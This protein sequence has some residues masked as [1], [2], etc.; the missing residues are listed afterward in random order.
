MIKVDSISNNKVVLYTGIFLLG[1]VL[2]WYMIELDPFLHDWDERIHALV[3]RNMLNDPFVP[4]LQQ[5]HLMPYRIENWVYNEIWLHKQPLFLWQIALS[6][7]LFGVSEFALRLPSALMGAASCVLLYRIAFLSFRNT[8]IAFLAALLWCFS[9]YQLELISGYVGMEHNDIAFSFYVLASIWAFYEFINKRSWQWAILIGAFAGCAILNKW[10]TGLLVFLPWGLFVFREFV[11]LKRTDQIKYFLVALVCCCIVFVPWQIYILYNFPAEARFEYLLN[12]K[13]ITIAVE[14]HSGPWY[15]YIQ[16]FTRYFGS[17]II[18]F[19]PFGIASIFRKMNTMHWANF[20]MGL[21]VFAFFSFIVQ[22]KLPSF[23]FIVVPLF[24]T[25]LAAGFDVL[26]T[27]FKL[28]K[29]YFI[30]ALPLVWFSLQPL[31]IRKNHLLP[32]S[33]QDRK[34]Q[35]TKIYKSLPPLLKENTHLIN[36][37]SNDNIELMFYNPKVI[38]SEKKMEIDSIKYFL[39]K[40][41]QIAVFQNSISPLHIDELSLFPNFTVLKFN[42]VFAE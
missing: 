6:F 18:L 25:Y 16:E 42:P 39:N 26:I 3:A 35:N 23:I 21:F 29:V 27:Q 37:P 8:R 28:H 10:L 15:Y 33:N 36:M 20:I 31:Q 11:L 40:G 13:H 19:I 38:S 32:D 30:L 24:V 17:F 2:R 1:F 22:T 34:E 9:H 41:R 7:K 4:M 14:G 5:E 12:R